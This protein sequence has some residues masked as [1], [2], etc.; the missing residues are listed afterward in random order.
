MA[1]YYPRVQGVVRRLGEGVIKKTRINVSTRI[2]LLFQIWQLKQS[3]YFLLEEVYSCFI[4]LIN[5]FRNIKFTFT[6]FG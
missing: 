6:N 2:I 3:N 5:M 4:S 1:D